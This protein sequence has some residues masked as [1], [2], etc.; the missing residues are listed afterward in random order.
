MGPLL[1]LHVVEPENFHINRV[2]PPMVDERLEISPCRTTAQV[3][4]LSTI[5]DEVEF[6]ILV[7]TG[8]FGV[9]H[10]CDPPELR[11]I[12]GQFRLG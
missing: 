11:M 10:H 2:G 4:M 1:R 6:L 5:S 12:L 3:N 8:S 9:T 7:G